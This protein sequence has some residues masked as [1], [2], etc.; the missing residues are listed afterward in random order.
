MTDEDFFFKHVGLISMEMKDYTM[1]VPIN[2]AYR[3]TFDMS[4][5]S[6]DVVITVPLDG[7][8]YLID[9]IASL[10]KERRARAEHPGLRDAYEK[11]KMLLELCK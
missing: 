7:A 8:R 10:E 5:R 3:S 6:P 9:T 2:G 4:Y 11:Y 1:A